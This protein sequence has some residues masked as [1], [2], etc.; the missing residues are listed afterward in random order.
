MFTV[1]P[2]PGCQTGFDI[3][4]A[5]HIFLYFNPY[6]T[7][8]FS[9]QSALSFNNSTMSSYNSF[10]DIIDGLVVSHGINDATDAETS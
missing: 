1:M 2:Q 8:H 9:L 10:N 6:L 7:S 4:W 5:L 3:L